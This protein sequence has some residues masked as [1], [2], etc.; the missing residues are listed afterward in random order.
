MMP[1]SSRLE[2]LYGSALQLYPARFRIAYA[3]AMRQAFRDALA[4]SSL[5]RRTFF[6]LAI[7][8]LIVTLAKEHFAM[9]RESLAPPRPCLQCFGPGRN[10][11]RAG[12]R[13]VRHSAAGVAARFE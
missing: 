3:S 9:M 11:H 10:L 12:V 7:V 4:D 5:D 2:R 6:L 8:D 1:Q 13:P